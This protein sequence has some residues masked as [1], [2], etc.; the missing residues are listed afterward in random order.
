MQKLTELVTQLGANPMAFILMVGVL[1]VLAIL[2][3]AQM[4]KDGFD[5]RSL[6]MENGEVSITK[7]GM[8]TA[9]GLSSWGFVYLL[10]YKEM[11]EFYFTGY[12]V[13]WTGSTLLASWIASKK[14]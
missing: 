12:M 6:I 10:L 11:T 7:T 9:L 5:L 8:I 3:Y 1:M 2:I 4:R 13:T 14:T